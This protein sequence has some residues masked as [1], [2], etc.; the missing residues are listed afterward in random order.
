MSIVDY[1]NSDV[2]DYHPYI[3]DILNA[4]NCIAMKCDHAY[5]AVVERMKENPSLRLFEAVKMEEP[6]YQDYCFRRISGRV[7]DEYDYLDKRV[8]FGN[9]VDW[10]KAEMQIE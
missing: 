4:Y 3:N 10:I 7:L 8:L 2:P 5:R 9:I 6:E 1:Y